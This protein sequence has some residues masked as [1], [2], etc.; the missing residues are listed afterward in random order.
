LH[1][2]WLAA[3]ASC[4]GDIDAARQLLGQVQRA[5]LTDAYEFVESLAAVVVEMASAVPAER[6]EVFCAVRGK[7][8]RATRR[9]KLFSSDPARRRLYRTCLRLIAQYRGGFAAKAWSRLHWLA[10]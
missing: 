7:L 5:S 3:D 6:P 9:Y 8:K 2:V 10:W 1:R 4:A